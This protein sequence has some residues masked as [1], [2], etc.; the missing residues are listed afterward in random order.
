MTTGSA[1]PS[2]LESYPD[3][4]VDADDQLTTLAA[5]LD[6][7]L[8]DFKDGASGYLSGDFDTE[9]AGA[10]VR[11]LRDESQHLSG[12]V[13]N[14]GAEFRRKGGDANGDG[15]FSADD[16]R[17]SHGIG[18]P[19]IAGAQA[20]ADGA[21]AASDLQ[22]QLVEMGIDPAHFDASGRRAPTRDRA[23]RRRD[24]LHNWS[25]RNPG[26]HVRGRTGGQSRRPAG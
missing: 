18:E 17:L 21:T 19:T 10:L 25:W 15:I 22:A 14:V 16:N 3:K 12:W 8:A 26:E 13:A 5:D 1:E 2:R 20:A 6:E 4:L 23:G 24:D 7:T 9:W 11:G